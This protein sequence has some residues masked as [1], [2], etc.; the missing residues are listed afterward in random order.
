[1]TPDASFYRVDTDLVLPQL[2][3]RN[4]TLRIDG[5]VARE[6]EIS[7]GELL[8]MPLTEADITLVCVSNEVGG[9]YNGN[10]AWL[11]VPLG[12]LLPAGRGAGRRRPGA[13]RRHRR[14]DHLHPGRRHHGRPERAAGR[15]DERPAAARRARIPGADDPPRPVR[16]R[17][18]G[19]VGYQA[20]PDHVRAAEGLLD[21][22]WL[23]RPGAHQDRIAHR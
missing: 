13:V 9:T 8:R 11:G 2:S 7:F 23:F 18:R 3:P 5:M 21:P 16:L 17:V 19:Q 10:A 15:R 14:D 22:A 1:L 20:D 6:A 4:W 12:G